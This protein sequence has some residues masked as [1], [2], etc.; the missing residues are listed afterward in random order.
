[1][2]IQNNKNIIPVAIVVAGAMLS[3]ALYYQPSGVTKAT[4][5]RKITAQTHESS[6]VADNEIF[7]KEGVIL[8]V[9]WGDMGKKLA[10]T[11]TIDAPRFQ[12]LYED[13][14]AYTDEYDLLLNG[15]TPGKLKITR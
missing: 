14:S 9:T 6:S 12:K 1:M 2:E 3:F 11:G 15:N 8:P 7:P 4:S 13:K 5:E 10:G